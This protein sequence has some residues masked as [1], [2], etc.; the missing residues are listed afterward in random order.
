MTNQFDSK[1]TR[2]LPT[3]SQLVE[4]ITTEVIKSYPNDLK[5]EAFCTAV[6]VDGINNAIEMFNSVRGKGNKIPNLTDMTPLSISMLLAARGDVALVAPG[7]KSL[8]HKKKVWTQ[9]RRMQLPIA[10]YQEDGDN[11]GVW[12]I[13]NNPKGAFGE[14]VERYKPNASKKEKEEV[15]NLVKSRLPIVEKCV[16]PY[17]VAV[18]NGIVDV[19]NKK[20]LPFSKDLVFTSKI[21]TELDFSATNPFIPIP[22]DGSVW[23][24]DSWLDSLGSPNFVKSIKEVIQAACTPLCNRGKMVIFQSTQGCNSKGTLSQLMRNLLGEDVTVSI[25]INGFSKRFALANLPEAQAIICDENSV[26]SFT[27][28]LGVLKAVITGDKTTIERKFEPAFDYAFSGLVLEC[29]NEH[30]IKGS[31]KTGSF[32]RRLHIISF[33][34]SFTGREKRYIKERLIYREDVLA[35]ILKQALIDTPYCNSFTE[36]EETKAAFKVYVSSSNNVVAFLDEVL[37]EA[38]WD[39]LPATDLLYEAYKQYAKRVNPSGNLIGRN[40]FIDG[41]K[42]YINTKTREN[43]NFEWEWTDSTRTDNYIDFSVCEPLV[44]N[45]PVEPFNRVMYESSHGYALVDRSKVKD[46]YSGLKRRKAASPSQ[47]TNTI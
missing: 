42:D 35:Y 10:M 31:D 37:E 40:E 16:I 39:L 30:S 38:Q 11:K 21:Q 45:Y 36:T 32:L 41:V 2:P 29:S 8:S 15:Y 28:D 17:Y 6:A 9:E 5:D 18:Q 47:G 25:P 46:K 44:E 34:E 20:L 26:N 22:E 4:E 14:I 27:Q 3:P 7:D 33:T 19:L 13:R 24:V 43:A 1:N 23:D 12:E